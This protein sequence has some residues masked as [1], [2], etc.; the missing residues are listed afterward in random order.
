M[1]WGRLF[2]DRKDVV[3]TEDL[4][5]LAVQFDFGAAVLADEHAVAFLDF[6]RDFFAVVIGLAGA[7]RNDDAF[8]GFFLG[9]IRNDDA[10]LFGFLL[11]D[12]FHEETIAERFDV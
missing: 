4:V 12:G 10:A 7:Q 3:R 5:F 8:H 11:F 2:N 6:E 1:A 9:G